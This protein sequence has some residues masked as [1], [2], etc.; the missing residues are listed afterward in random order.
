MIYVIWMLIEQNFFLLLGKVA[1]VY[2]LIACLGTQDTCS[3][4]RFNFFFGTSREELCFDDDWLLGQN[5][6]TQNL[7][8]TLNIKDQLVI[9]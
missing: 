8:I 2:S 5:T 7:V 4:N 6:F 9:N 3:T 1:D